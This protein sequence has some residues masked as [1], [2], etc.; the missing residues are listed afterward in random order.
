M[1]VRTISILVSFVV[2]S[3]LLAWTKNYRA[4][5]GVTA[6]M[7]AAL[8]IY[9]GAFLLS[10]VDSYRSTKMVALRIDRLL[11]PGERIAFHHEIRESSLFY[12]DRLAV[13]LRSADEF[14]E[15]IRREGALAI[16]DLNWMHKIEQLQAH[17]RIVEQYGNRVIVEGVAAP[18]DHILE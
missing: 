3:A 10:M 17:Y 1:T 6:T 7:I 5:F 16:V 13:A 4:L 12:T 8:M 18:P 9:M 15:H 14:E 2:L 11:P